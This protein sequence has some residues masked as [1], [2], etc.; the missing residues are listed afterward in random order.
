VTDRVDGTALPGPSGAAWGRGE[1]AAVK[2]ALGAYQYRFLEI[3][4]G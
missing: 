4:G 2:V 3:T 1:L